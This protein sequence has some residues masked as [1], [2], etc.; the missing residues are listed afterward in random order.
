MLFQHCTHPDKTKGQVVVSF[1]GFNSHLLIV[2]EVS[3][4]M[5]VFLT[6][7]KEPPLDIARAFLARFG[8]DN[9][10]IIRTDQGG[11]LARSATF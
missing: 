11:E 5:W 6:K 7:S 8:H 10:G 9:G 3:R 4:F 1:D 2:D